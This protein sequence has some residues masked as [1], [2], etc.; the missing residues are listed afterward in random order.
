MYRSTKIWLQLVVL[1]SITYICEIYRLM[2]GADASLALFLILMRTRNYFYLLISS[3]FVVSLALL[4][5]CGTPRQS[6]NRQAASHYDKKLTPAQERELV[7]EAKEWLGAKYRYG[8]HSRSGTDCSGMVM[9][10]YRKVCGVKLPR[11]SREQCDFCEKIKR[12]ELRS[13]DLVFFSTGKSKSTVSH[14]GLYIGNGEIIHASSSRGV[15]VSRLDERYF[16][17]AYHSSGRVLAAAGVAAAKAVSIQ[18][19]GS[20]QSSPTSSRNGK[21]E[22]SLEE[23]VKRTAAIEPSPEK[24][25]EAADPSLPSSLLLDDVIDQK[26]DSIYSDLFD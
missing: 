20:R 13:G 5:G 2:Y 1:A 24:K 7:K 25:N 26:I 4:T 17:R 3:M 14:V 18:S 11:S 21:R 23:L 8:G 22:I 6:T 9:E 12:D 16:Q 19:D 15:I 10:V